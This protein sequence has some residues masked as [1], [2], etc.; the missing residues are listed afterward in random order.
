MNM[1][2]ALSL[3]QPLYQLLPRMCM[4]QSLKWLGTKFNKSTP[5]DI[6]LGTKLS[7]QK[8]PP[9]LAEVSSHSQVLF[10]RPLH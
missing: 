5:E 9:R 7:L 3:Q 8:R 2:F 4:P 10:T 1:P 6:L